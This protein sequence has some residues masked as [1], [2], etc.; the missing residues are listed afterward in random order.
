[1]AFRRDDVVNAIFLKY[2]KEGKLFSSHAGIRNIAS[3][4][5]YDKYFTAK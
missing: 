5:C 3:N 1:M 2:S 4:I